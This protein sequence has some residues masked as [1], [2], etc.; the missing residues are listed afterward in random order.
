MAG[1]KHG[2]QGLHRGLFLHDLGQVLLDLVGLAV[3]DLPMH[4]LG[5]RHALGGVGGGLGFHRG[6]PGEML[7]VLG[8]GVGVAVENQV[9]GQLALLLGDGHVGLDVRRVE[10]GHV[11]PGLHAVVKEDGIQNFARGL[12]Q[13]EGHVGNAPGWSAPPG[14]PS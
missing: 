10:D 5:G 4:L 13:A 11:E 12:G 9:V 1:K 6:L 14:S 2:V 7:D 3:D 8:Q